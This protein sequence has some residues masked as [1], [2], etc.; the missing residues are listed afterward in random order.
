MNEISIC[1]VN[2]MGLN[3]DLKRRDVFDRLRNYKYS[4][5]CMVD[6]HFDK[7]KHKIY[8][9]EWG[10]T[11]YYNSFSTNKRGVAI[12]FRNSFEFKVHHAIRDQNG[13]LL[14]LDLEIEKHRISLAVIY[15][16][17]QDTPS[18][19]ENLKNSLLKIG[20]EKIIIVGD[21]NMLLDPEVDGKNYKISIIP[22]PDKQFYNL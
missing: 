22:T 19:Y 5:V 11:C 13:N 10:Y 2:V 9:S 17:N 14:I 6:T 8:S 7:Q 20:N 21:W 15:G 16:P 12:F 4:I 1:C 3:Q 18:F